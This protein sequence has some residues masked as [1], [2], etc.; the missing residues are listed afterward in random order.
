MRAYSQNFVF[1]LRSLDHILPDSLFVRAVFCDLELR[2]FYSSMSSIAA[3]HDHEPTRSA[4]LLPEEFADDA[5]TRLGRANGNT[6]QRKPAITNVHDGQIMVRLKKKRFI[7]LDYGYTPNNHDHFIARTTPHMS[8]PH[9]AGQTKCATMGCPRIGVPVLLYDSEPHEPMS[10]YLRGGLCFSCQRNLN[11]KRR[12]QRKRKGE[13]DEQPVDD[14]PITNG[15]VP[16]S[17]IPEASNSTRYK[18]ND[19]IAELNP[20]AI[21]INCPVTGTRTH[22]PDYGC[23]EIGND[24]LRTVSKLSQE[25]LSLMQYTSEDPAFSSPESINAQYQQA[26]LSASRATFL[27]TQWKA[28]YD[29]QQRTDYGTNDQVD[30]EILDEAVHSTETALGLNREHDVLEEHDPYSTQPCFGS[31]NIERAQV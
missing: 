6:Y 24:L 25:T 21:V 22:G 29:A 30:S 2:K 26:F 19:Q 10:L 27:L 18:Y 23:H 7:I 15:Q 5:N 28:S 12:T 9:G 1:H 20:D 3:N 11:E 13:V 31:G 16:P 14:D 4:L 17:I 8:I